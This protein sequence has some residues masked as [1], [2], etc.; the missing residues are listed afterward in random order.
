MDRSLLD[1]LASKFTEDGMTEQEEVFRKLHDL[2]KSPIE[3]IYVASRVLG[4]SLPEA[5]TALYQSA[6]WRDQHENWQGIQASLSDGQD[7]NLH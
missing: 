4:L 1:A 5:K 3:T 6:S 2:G 7:N